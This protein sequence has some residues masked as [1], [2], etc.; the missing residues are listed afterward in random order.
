[1]SSETT[2]MSAPRALHC[3]RDIELAKGYAELDAKYGM[4][5][6]PRPAGYEEYYKA[7][8]KA[9]SRFHNHETVAAPVVVTNERD[10]RNFM[11][12]GESR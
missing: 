8:Y 10:H 5:F 3:Y 2:K 6:M 9:E 11:N 7:A 4:G 12:H 1:M